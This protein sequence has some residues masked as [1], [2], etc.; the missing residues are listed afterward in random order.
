MSDFWWDPSSTSIL[1]MCDHRRLWRDCADAQARLSL[2]WSPVWCPIISCDHFTTGRGAGR[3]AG[4]LHWTTL[5]LDARVRLRP[6][7]VE[8]PVDLFIV[9][10]SFFSGNLLLCT[11]KFYMSHET[12]KRVFGSFRSGQTQTGLRSH[13][14]WLESWNFGYKI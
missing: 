12:T 1:H 14:S 2:R 11:D 8:F 5:L 13:R 7:T 4:R 6:L 3:C 9:F 10:L